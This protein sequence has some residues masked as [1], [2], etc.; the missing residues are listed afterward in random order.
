MEDEILWGEKLYPSL[1]THWFVETLLNREGDERRCIF[2]GCA[3]QKLR[4]WERYPIAHN[5]ACPS[6]L[7]VLKTM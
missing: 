4:I 1:C 6:T 2:A 3:I 5:V 7:P